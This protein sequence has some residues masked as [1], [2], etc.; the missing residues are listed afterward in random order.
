MKETEPKNNEASQTNELPVMNNASGELAIDAEASREPYLRPNP[1]I[2]IADLTSSACGITHG[3]WCDAAREPE[4]I[5]DDIH[6]ML[7]ASPFTIHHFGS[8]SEIPTAFAIHDTEHFG[9]RTIRSDDSIELVAKIARGIK[10]HGYAFAAWADVQEGDPEL[11]DHF[12]TAYVGHYPSLEVYVQYQLT[13]RGDDAALEEV[14]RTSEVRH[15]KGY[16]G[17]NVAAIARDLFLSGDIN[18]YKVSA[19]LGGGVWLFD[20]RA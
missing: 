14:M 16:V 3:V 15:L 9:N 17:I 19:E 11:L 8:P 4:A 5:Y 18:V 1:R 13:E 10:Q 12:A 7:E 6:Q 2:Y 20:E